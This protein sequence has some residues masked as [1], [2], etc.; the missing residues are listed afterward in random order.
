VDPT[1]P[2]ATILYHYF[3]P[4][5]VVSARHLTDLAVGLAGR[6]WQVT[7]VPSNRG[8]REEGRTYP[9][10]DEVNGVCIRRVWR[11]KFRQASNSGR[12]LNAAWMLAGW[13]LRGAFGRRHGREVVVVGTD[14]V[15]SVLAA[16]PWRTFRTRCPVAH[17]CFDL[18]PEAAIADGLVRAD[19]PALRF[20]RQILAAAYRRCAL[21][22]D[23]GPCMA[24][25][26]KVYGSPARAATLT[27]WA[28]VEPTRP[29]DPD[30]AARRDLFGDAG[31]GLLYSGNFG[32]AHSYAEF[33]Q[34]ARLLRNAPIR[35]CFAGR[36]NR[37]E[38]LRA[39]VRPEDTNVTF[40]GFAPESELERR[41]G[42]C[43]LHLVSLRPEWTGTVVPSK[44]F[45]A[46]A[47][48]RGVLFAGSA[49]S[50]V[51][52][53]VREYQVGWVLSAD[54][55]PAVAADLRA[56]AA[57][58]AR[59]AGLRARCHAVYHAHFS[60]TR[61]LDRWDA[62]LRALLEPMTGRKPSTTQAVV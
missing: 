29:A 56:L 13:G 48:G 49:E 38:E 30:P 11:P 16:L 10:R 36:G 54:A 20:L 17:W 46:L 24:G 44:F 6:G 40:A 33:L 43:D 41:L 35:F 58:P 18:Y 32:R 27:P 1:R 21:I 3:H 55:L 12:L 59:L 57:N 45:G 53:W 15:L 23:L 31:L 2:H 47:A 5:D 60:K 7:A 22:A 25:R 26:L 52:R 4:D 8:C 39:A 50:A 62:E 51:A 14:P 19:S 9:A 34:L 61:Q 28:L 37:V 42:A